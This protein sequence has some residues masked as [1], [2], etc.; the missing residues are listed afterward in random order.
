[1]SMAKCKNLDLTRIEKNKRMTRNNE[2]LK[3][4]KTY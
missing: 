1:M 3:N 4:K 2:F